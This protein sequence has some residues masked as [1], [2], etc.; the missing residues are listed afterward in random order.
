MITILENI[1]NYHNKIND[2]EVDPSNKNIITTGEKLIF[3][4]N[5]K[6]LKEIAGKVKNCESIKYIREKNQ[7]FASNIFFVSTVIG[8]IYKGDSLKKKITETVFET[9]KIIEFI[10]FTTNGKIIYI[11]NNTLYSYDIGTKD[12]LFTPIF[13]DSK[14]SRGNYKIFINGENIILKYRE[15]HEQT[16]IINIFDSKLNKIFEVKTENNHIYSIIDELEYIAGT[17]SGEIEI[18]NI[19]EGEM[20][21]S[22]KISDMRITYIEKNNFYYFIG[23]GN[24][25]IVIT[26]DKFKILNLQSVFKNE[27]R[28]IC[29]IENNLYVLGTENKIA[30][31]MLLENDESR[32]E[33]SFRKN[34]IETY[35]IHND[36]YD[37]FNL[38]RI[39]EIENFLRFLE[40]QNVDFTPQKENI[41]RALSDSISSRR[42]C[43]IGKDPYFQKGLA[44]G[45]SFEVQKDSWED[46]EV[47]ASLKNILKLIYR[48]YTGKLK[49]INEIKADIEKGK[50]KIL[51]PDKIF[52]SWKEQGVLLLNSALTTVVGKAGEH[53]GFWNNFTKELLEYISIKNNS[54]VYFL[55]GKDAELFE[56]NILSGDIIKHNHPAICG[57]LENEKDFLNGIS[58]RNT[59]NIIDWTGYEEKIE[60]PK[61]KEKE[62]KNTLF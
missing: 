10:D 34:F 37:F 11:E 51:D 14:K 42:V 25:D 56:K 23:L 44:T 4:K 17:A 58:F 41:F 39:S 12:S 30:E 20:Y 5:G 3:Y 40:I 55:W 16:N 61:H 32:R 9:E 29:V 24:G 47:N 33:N 18:W 50:F 1:I 49:D 8:N 21:N 48:T 7:L 53:H 13:Y 27:I 36:Y 43:I 26:D 59:V 60:M 46:P 57:N 54:V 31:L 15:L 62:D 6:K 19:L 52:L 35:G 2:F 38:K 28:K 22:I 45:L